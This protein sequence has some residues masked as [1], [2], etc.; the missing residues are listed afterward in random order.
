MLRTLNISFGCIQEVGHY[1]LSHV[2]PTFFPFQNENFSPLSYYSPLS[3]ICFWIHWWEQANFKPRILLNHF[4]QF[5]CLL[6]LA[7]FL[8][9]FCFLLFK[10]FIY[11][12]LMLF[13]LKVMKTSKRNHWLLSYP[14]FL[15]FL[16]VLIC[17]C[18]FE[19]SWDPQ[20]F[21]IPVLCAVLLK[22]LAWG[23]FGESH[24][25]VSW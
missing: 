19:L 11:L 21:G 22:S 13:V 3:L 8:F 4:I 25:I 24:V 12:F 2:P 10:N 7:C 17:W 14:R 5:F 23:Y 18:I 9:V 15:C 20:R 16:L 1:H 6:W